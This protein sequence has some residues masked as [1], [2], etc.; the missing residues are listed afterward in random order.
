MLR[1]HTTSLR[2]A[3]VLVDFLSAIGL[4]VLVSWVRFGGQWQRSW[5]NA[6]VDPQTLAL[7][8]GVGWVAVI[9][10]QGLY[11]LRTRWSLRSEAVDVLK[12]TA[13]LALTTFALLFLIRLPD[14][15]RLFLLTLLPGQAVLTLLLRFGLRGLFAMVRARGMNARFMLVVGTGSEAQAF[16]DRVE[17]H[18]ELGIRVV[19]HLQG[20]EE[21]A[22]PPTRPVLGR[23]EDIE[24]MLH[25]QVI[26]EVAVCL[27]LAAWHLVE[28]VARLCEDEGKVVRIPVA[29]FGLSLAAGQLEDFDGTPVLSM[30]YGPDRAVALGIKRAV[31][32]SLAL[33]ALVLTSPVMLAIAL[34]VLAV[35]G[36]PVLFRQT[37]VGLHG[38]PF[39]LL[40]FR[41]MVPDAEARL[42]QLGALN[43]IRGRAFKLTRDPR[44]TRTG[45]WL[46]RTSLDELP[47]LWNV[48]RG[49]M[50]LVGPRP[51]L[52]TEVAGYD[53][54]HRR[55]LS[56][57]PGITGLWQ[58]KA[59]D[60][61]EFDRWVEI[62]LD[63]IDRWS[64][65]LDLQIM[66]RTIPAVIGQQ[67]R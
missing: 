26:D 46:R 42:A 48:L 7:G 56:M 45:R 31:D 54:W 49:E 50:S 27:P 32:L 24:S 15:S 18:R 60:E 52:P 64:L 34:W 53:V 36:R 4:F 58:V 43:E 9:W 17:S 44:L 66:L 2:M 35:E 13:L 51:P 11:R 33:V 67:G 5:E 23:L 1:R 61:P 12:A 41:T 40:K 62:D 47:Q 22:Q 59:R 25:E 16:A 6:E 63:Y 10:L 39:T 29:P 30:V 28:P 19:G 57:K 14:V 21:A 8:Y 55:R 3:L 20:P 38:R 37:R 65:W